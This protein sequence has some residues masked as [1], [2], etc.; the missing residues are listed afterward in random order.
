LNGLL[1]IHIEKG[2]FVLMNQNTILQ[3]GV[4]NE[5]KNID[6]VKRSGE[7]DFQ[8]LVWEKDS[9]ANHFIMT[10]YDYVTN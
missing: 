5:E 10:C 7:Y 2:R 3:Q 4:S 9:R 1:P 8:I 6:I